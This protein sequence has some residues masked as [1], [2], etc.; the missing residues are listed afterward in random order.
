MHDAL[1]EGADL[2]WV[3]AIVHQQ[4]REENRELFRRV[5]DALAP[6]GRVL[7]RDIVLEPDR[8]APPYGAL[9]AVNMLVSTGSGDC[10]TFEELQHD[11]YSAGFAEIARIRAD[12]GMN[13][14]LSARK[15][16]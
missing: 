3:S 13:T 9:F 7:V 12:E 15:A 6:G 4:G 2:A 14:V 8:T 11:L 10:F 16:R 1:P 5:Y